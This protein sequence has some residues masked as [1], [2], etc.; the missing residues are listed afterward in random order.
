MRAALEEEQGSGELDELYK[1]LQAE[2]NELQ[3]LHEELLREAERLRREKAEA[4]L[5]L[6][7]NRDGPDLSASEEETRR[8]RAEIS[9]LCGM[10]GMDEDDTCA[11]GS[12]VCLSL[13]HISEPTRLL[14]ISYAVFCLKKKN[15]H[16]CIL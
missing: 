3:G 16:L 11:L 4:E 2:H 6:G 10:V 14:S 13:I 1:R 5:E 15:T 9:K 12:Q 7:A 8:L